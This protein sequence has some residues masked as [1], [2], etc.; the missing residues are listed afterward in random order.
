MRLLILAIMCAALS[1]A[2]PLRLHPDNPHYF[3][4]R[5]RPVLLITS[6]EHYGAVLNT[7]FDYRKYL[8]T[9]AADGLN[10]TRIFT[11]VYREIPGS[12]NIR[13]N[14]LAPADKDF[15]APFAL[16]GGKYDL[17][18]WNP[19]YFA[20]LKGFLAEAGKRN[21]VVEISLF[22]TFYEDELWAMSPMNAKNNIQ[23]VGAV[24]RTEVLTLRHPELVK[25]QEAFVRKMA[26]ELK[27]YGNFFWEI[28][29]E[30]YF[31]GVALDW[32]RRISSVLIEAEGANRHVIA[33]NIA[34]NQ[35]E[36][37]DPDPNV[38]LFNFH[39]AR[40]PATVAMNWHLRRPVG[41]DESGFDGNHESIYRIQG[42]DFILAGGALYNNLDYSFVAGNEDGTFEYPPTQPGGGNAALR[43]SLGAL[44]R[45]MKTFELARMEPN[46]RLA[47]VPAGDETSVR[48]LSEPGRAHAVYLHR[49]KLLRGARPQYVVYTEEQSTPLTLN[50]SA[51][52]WHARWW[53]PKTGGIEKEEDIRHEGGSLVLAT[54]RYREDIALELRIVPGS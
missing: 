13:R 4:Y 36:V 12:F 41:F 42:W 47:V 11:G 26:A 21:V 43:R 52:K 14:T 18:Q 15:L 35:A 31:A 37:R 33:Q 28:C 5:G 23:G 53:N 51:G 38:T 3:E 29:N 9:L 32:Q 7:A 22:C 2:Q 48:A 16:T 27:G 46:A 20:R 30:P 1:V 49:G 40:P 39:Y 10:Y 34:N 6:G 24:P 54:P 8:D 17:S 19:A 45:F 44:V 50:V 25:V